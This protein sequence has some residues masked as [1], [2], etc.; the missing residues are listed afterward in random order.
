MPETTTDRQHE[1]DGK[2]RFAFRAALAY[3]ALGLVWILGS[4]SYLHVSG[5]QALEISVRQAAKGSLYVGLSSL[6]VFL[7]VRYL[8]TRQRWLPALVALAYL[9]LGLAWIFG[10]DLYLYSRGALTSEALATQLFKGSGFVAVSAFVIY[11]VTLLAGRRT[12]AGTPYGAAPRDAADLQRVRPFPIALAFG[13]LVMAI[14]LALCLYQFYIAQSLSAGSFRAQVMED[15]FLALFAGATLYGLMRYF[16]AR[17]M[18]SARQE[19]LSEQRYHSLFAH[20]P[21]GVCMVDRQGRFLEANRAFCNVFGREEDELLRMTWEPL[22]EPAE[23]EDVGRR[24]QTVLTGEAQ[25]YEATI[26]RPDGE[27]LILDVANVPCFEVDDVVAV[28][29]VVRD[30][31]AQ[32]KAR[33]RIATSEERFRLLFE[34]S[35]Y[36]VFLTRPDGTIE[37]ANPAAGAM[38]GL[39]EAE[40]I[41]RGRDGVLDTDDPALIDMLAERSRTGR[42]HG[43]LHFVH[44]D[45]TKVPAE[46]TTSRYEGADGTLLSF[47]MARDMSEQLRQE[48]HLKASEARMRAVFDHSMDAI[49]LSAPDE[50]RLLECNAAAERL[51]GLPEAELKRG[52]RDQMFDSKDPALD[53]FIRD[54]DATG[55]AR[56][57]LTAIHGDGSPVPVEATTAVFED[58]QG[59]R[60]SSVILRDISESLRRERELRESEDRYRAL[61]ENSSDAILIGNPDGRAFDAN[62]A[63]E[64]LFGLPREELCDLNRE[65]MLDPND[66]GFKELH[67]ERLAH[68]RAR[69]ELQLRRSDG[70]WFLAD[71]TAVG[72]RN[73]EGEDR[74]SIVI[75]DITE[76]KRQQ[77]ALEQSEERLRATVE[78]SLDPIVGMDAEG[79]IIQFNEAAEGCFGYQRDQV[80][81]EPL[82][83]RL[84][85]ERFR[86]AHREG[87]ERYLKT[88]EGRVVGKRIEVTGLRA[89]G[90]EFPAELAI[91]VTKGPGG[92]IFV[93]YM[94][95]ITEQRRQERALQE[96]EERF[97]SIYEHSPD[98]ILNLDPAT[99]RVLTVNAAAEKLFGMDKKAF[100]RRER[101]QHTD[102][103]DPAF[104]KFLQDRERTG[105]ARAVLT[106]YRGD[107]T[108]FP[109]DV[110]S[111]VYHDSDGRQWATAIVR[112]ISEQRE[113]E[114]EIRAS[115]ERYRALFEQSLDAIFI[116]EANTLELVGANPAA[117]AL[118]GMTEEQLCAR[119]P[120]EAMDMDDPSTREYLATRQ[121]DGQARARLRMRR[122]DGTW[123]TAE[124]TSRL[125]RNAAGRRLANSIIRDI[126]EQEEYERQ[127]AESDERFRIIADNTGQVIYEI[128]LETGERVWA[129]ACVEMFG[130]D[131]DELHAMPARERLMH[132]PEAERD[133][134]AAQYR[135]AA[136]SGGSF[137][138]DY[139]L[140]T[141]DGGTILVEDRG[142]V[143]KELGRMYGVIQDVTEKRRLLSDL[144]AREQSLAEVSRVQQAILDALSAHIALL[145][146]EGVVQYVNTA[147][148]RFAEAN[149]Y[150]GADAGV[151]SN[152]LSVCDATRGRD[153]K[154]ARQ[155]AR[156]IRQVMAGERTSFDTEY[157]CHSPEERRWFRVSVTPFQ[158]GDRSGAVVA[159]VNISDRKEAERQ[160][161]L[162]ATAFRS[163]DEA[164]LICNADFEILDV[165][166][167]YERII[168]RDRDDAIG[169]RP[170]FLEIE[171]QE[172]NIRRALE[173]EGQWRGELLQRRM[174]G[175]A[176][177]SRASVSEVPDPESGAPHL[178]VS[179]SDVSELREYERR[180]DYLSY[181]DALTGL[182]NRAAL[183]EWFQAFDW[184]PDVG[185]EV[186]RLA[187]VFIDLDRLKTVNDA[188]GHNVGDELITELGRRLVAVCEVDDYAA[189]LI[190]DEFVMV[191]SGVSDSGEAMDEVRRRLEALSVPLKRGEF[192]IHP[193]VCAGIALAPEHGTSL[194][195]L[196]RKADVAKHEAKRQGRGETVL[197]SAEMSEEVEEQILIEHQLRGGIDNREFL[198]HYQPSVELESGRIIGVE[199]L[200]RWENPQLG[201]VPPDRFIPVAEDSGL[202]IELGDWVFE[203]VCRQISKWQSEDVP[204]GWIAVNLS[205]I[206]FQDPNL[207]Q[208][209]RD[210]MERHGVSGDRIRVEITES[211]LV[212]DPD[213]TTGV[214]ESLRE[215]GIKIA[216]DD[217]GT[218]YSSLAYLKQFP[219]DYVKLDKTFIAGLPGDS[220]DASIVASV[221][222][223]AR[224]LGMG[225]VAEGIERE[226]QR[227]FL[228]EAGCLEAQGYYFSLPLGKADL[229]WLFRSHK[230]L[231]VGKLTGKETESVGDE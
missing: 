137:H 189:R 172:R 186:S 182:P 110:T 123:F 226:E 27:R 171:Q 169:S 148:R 141:R 90:E 221:V 176:F 158:A 212:M 96:S 164:M 42:A 38:L 107:G 199:A 26:V 40:I 220:A 111:G 13:T 60:R 181:H 130:Y 140:M 122:G 160:L 105:H 83:E 173:T 45:G 174:D 198:L 91:N 132:T 155:T 99:G 59:N 196:L 192:M 18:E 33:D 135:E 144:E 227:R 187:F 43:V 76:S 41:E 11:L 156:G 84:M 218:G 62:P 157:P 193:T 57:V 12:R 170:L 114:A 151:G 108:G 78:A 195:Q 64:R 52:H 150:L 190:G 161:E 97:R 56:G 20:N 134:V 69:A 168:G 117:Q 143:L 93:G 231:P 208:K 211:V 85:P 3:L 127:L 142:I 106:M 103:D 61:F 219:V 87:L 109:A 6:A 81:G 124:V 50:G 159:H 63:A 86:K 206:Q 68:G 7:L 95:D 49:L 67:A 80:L 179:F 102:V 139:P 30:I 197:F 154:A 22:V 201:L 120:E 31:T 29:A 98:A 115:E 162:V 9:L 17:A 225:V 166:H 47:V 10:S 32:R 128:D 100:T 72:F 177:V 65:D 223:L 185:G 129:G 126:T 25:Y 15:L 136:R 35:L 149:E 209:I 147:W 54:R 14:S 71:V 214:L 215:L 138:F 36:A 131:H 101:P 121:R 16:M 44:A 125:F 146:S 188:Y 79:R 75:R 167:A 118:F 82:A 34:H 21:S 46:V 153:R 39:S 104:K 178:V 116:S 2:V 51:F 70:T 165:N 230:T 213:W 119:V 112:D 77:V 217:F 222:D 113:R 58:E 88:G 133:R 228:L 216:V 204:F 210:C 28:Y 207:L 19:H 66:P 180:V 175:Q 163:A 194:E 24:F 229:P 184:R 183:A 4:E 37:A 152:Y 73:L 203:E 89:D 8:P 74:T 191:I 224:R 53:E 94:R 55:H 23:L 48:A 1:P 145:D 200:V 5:S 92:T 205:P 202:I